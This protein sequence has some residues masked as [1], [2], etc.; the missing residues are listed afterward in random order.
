MARTSVLLFYGFNDT[1]YNYLPA[2]LTDDGCLIIY[3][4]ATASTAATVDSKTDG[5]DKGSN[6]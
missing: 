6:T 1:A 4:A 3:T 5:C 2:S